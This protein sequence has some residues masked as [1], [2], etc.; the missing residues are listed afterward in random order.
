MTRLGQYICA[1]FRRLI[2]RLIR[3]SVD[4]I[5]REH[6]SSA[7]TAIEKTRPIDLPDISHFRKRIEDAASHIVRA[8]GRTP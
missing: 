6:M 1:L 3:P 2:T 5:L 7:V 4:V 8:A